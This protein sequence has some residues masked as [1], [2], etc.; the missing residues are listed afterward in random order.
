MLAGVIASGQKSGGVTPTQYAAAGFVGD[1]AYANSPAIA[2]GGSNPNGATDFE[3]QA[4]VYIEGAYTTEDR[5]L[6]VQFPAGRQAGIF[7]SNLFPAVG[8]VVGDSQTGS[9][10]GDFDGGASATG[11]W[12]LMTFSA[13]GTPAPTGLWRAT[14][15]SLDG[16]ISFRTGG[17]TKGVE[18]SL[19]GERVDL[20]GGGVDTGWTNGIRYAEVRAYN[21][22][23]S[24]AQRQ[25]D[26]TNTDPTGAV[27]WWRFS[28]DG[29]GG[30]TTTDIT[31]NGLEPTLVGATLETGP[32]F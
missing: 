24:D 17:R 31:G 19:Q 10:G 2:L 12:C 9:V 5:I 22:Q 32:L 16:T 3:V 6:M 4:L 7:V 13:D 23:R 29:M 27:F 1:S 28:D 11:A 8:L 18:D 15:E 20:N 30:V 21:A 26:L 14:L 25:L